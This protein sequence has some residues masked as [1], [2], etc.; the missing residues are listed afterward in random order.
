MKDLPDL[1]SKRFNDKI[2]I[3]VDEETKRLWDDLRRVHKK[4]NGEWGRQLLREGFK[5]LQETKDKSAS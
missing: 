1:D 4:N 3:P 2:S 5:R